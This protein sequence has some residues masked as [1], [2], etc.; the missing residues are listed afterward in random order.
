[1]ELSRAIEISTWWK[2]LFF[3]TPQILLSAGQHGDVVT[4]NGGGQSPDNSC[5]F[6]AWIHPF[7]HLQLYQQVWNH[8]RQIYAIQTCQA[9]KNL[10]FFWNESQSLKN[11]AVLSF[12]L[13]KNFLSAHEWRIALGKGKTVLGSCTSLRLRRGLSDLENFHVLWIKWIIENCQFCY[14]LAGELELLYNF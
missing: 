5:R 2:T 13:E 10:L 7:L 6:A 12:H 4:L 1:M 3:S 9:G 11:R 14:L 8:Q